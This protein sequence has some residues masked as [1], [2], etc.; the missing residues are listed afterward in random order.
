MTQSSLARARLS[1]AKESAD[2]ARADHLA[3]EAIAADPDYGAA[4]GFRARIAAV[5]GDPVRAAHYFR[6][7]FA[8]GDRTPVT[9]YGL[10]V[11]LA[12]VGQQVIASRIADGHAAPQDMLDFAEQVSSMVPV[13]QQMLAAALPEKG[14]AALMPNERLPSFSSPGPQV[15]AV[16]SQAPSPVPSPLPGPAVRVERSEPSAVEGEPTRP[17]AWKTPPEARKTPPEARKKR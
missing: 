12:A 3:L 1:E 9:R 10:S 13:I 17:E 15:R 8:R 16:R 14:R 5:T 4:Y 7:A 2:R 11:C 6:V